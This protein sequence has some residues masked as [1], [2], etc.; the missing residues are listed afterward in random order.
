MFPSEHGITNGFTD[1]DLRIAGSIETLGEAVSAD[2]YRTAGFSNNP[3]VGKL[4]GL[5]RGFDEYV[6]WDLE[7]TKSDGAPIHSSREEVY[8]RV[9]SLL[10][11]AARQP[12]FLL[13]RRFFTTSLVDRA[14]RWIDQ[15]AD[16][17]RPTFTFLNLME[18][19]SPY[20][21]P[22][23]AFRELNL[24]PPSVVEP[25]LLNTN[26]LAYTMQ[27]RDLTEERRARALEY[28][29]ASL[30]YE[31]GKLGELLDALRRAGTFDD[32]LIIVCADHGKTLGEFDRTESPPHYIR[33]LNLNVPLVVKRPGQETAER[34]TTPFELHRL[35]DVV[36]DGEDRPLSEYTPP[37][38]LAMAEDYVPHTGRESMSVTRWRTLTDESYKYARTDEGTEHLFERNGL[39]ERIVAAD[40]ARE[41][42]QRLRDALSE[43]EEALSEPETTQGNATDSLAQSTEAQLSDLGYLK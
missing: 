24:D 41:R 35:F 27:K 39:E 5:S 26:L 31:D 25:R 38:G 36:T 10:G 15:T 17:A 8:S 3:W 19:H 23:D 34:I 1:R 33:D 2:G 32:T 6:E 14:T 18:A 30:R 7:V 11:H 13:K 37:N 29:D 43:R 28:Y 4:S 21:P 12:V 9:H 40:E 22:K 20:F 42:R 16:D